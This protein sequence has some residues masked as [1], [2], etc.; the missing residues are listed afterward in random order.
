[1]KT[2]KDLRF[3]I[4]MKLYTGFGLVLA[5]MVAIAGLSYWYMV[6]TS[7]SYTQLI[8]EDS[9]SVQS[10]KNLALSVE[11]Q[12]S[13]LSEYLLTGNEESLNAYNAARADFQQTLQELQPLISDRDEQQIVAGLDLL[14]S[15][16]RSAAAQ[17]IE[18]K[19]QGNTEAY[20][21]TLDNQ[22]VVLNKFSSIS[23]EFAQTKQDFLVTEAQRTFEAANYTKMIVMV[24]SLI[25]L[26]IGIFISLYISRMISSPLLK[27]QTVAIK[28]AQG[29]LRDT[30]VGVKNRDEIGELA[31][32]FNYMGENLRSLIH[33][34]GSHS[35]QVALSSNQL[36]SSADQTGQATEH[37]AGIT[38]ELASGSEVQ[39][40]QVASGV[41]LV[42]HIDDEAQRISQ[43]SSL[44]VHSATHASSVASEGSDAVRVAVQ[45]MSAVEQNV[46]GLAGRVSQMGERSK[47]IGD[48]IAIIT[49]IAQQ[50]NL[51]SLN[52]S[53]EAARA[54]EQGRGFAVVAG[55]VRKLAEQTA[56]SG[57]QVSNV[58]GTLQNDMQFI[59]EMVAQG[60]QEVRSG[61]E[62]VGTAGS[63]FALIEQAV[64][65]FTGQIQEV[66]EAATQMSNETSDVVNAFEEINQISVRM[67]EGSQ[68][69]SASA[70]EQLAS[71]QEITAASKEL[72]SLSHELRQSVDK[73]IV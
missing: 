61:I 26:A 59:I 21:Q 10:I 51:L 42:R 33:E 55:E 22:A 71:V 32:S 20:L 67:A 66:S 41:A 62:A 30:R 17:M 37:V 15:Y 52:A 57:Q 3:S 43:N 35:K 68:S 46:T 29:D 44:V 69:V 63:S 28:I 60:A 9:A 39:A 38:E 70:E 5:L 45:Q 36:S 1:M 54:G 7:N 50:T 13:Q 56:L 48:I 19:K 27:L 25:T 64:T 58:I 4:K 31:A 34:V 53:I 2:K 23:L 8:N 16:F 65:E 24:V 47:E 18:F 72:A 49:S 40:R 6:S 11:R 14:Q 73:F 12:H